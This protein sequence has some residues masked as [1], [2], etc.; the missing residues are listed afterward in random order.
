VGFVF[1]LLVLPLIG[2]VIF[3]LPALVAIVPI[4]LVWSALVRAIA[5]R[6][7]VPV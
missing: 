1:G 5:R 2:I 7:D 3:G 4:A 6:D